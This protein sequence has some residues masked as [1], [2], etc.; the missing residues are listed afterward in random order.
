MPEADRKTQSNLQRAVESC[1]QKAIWAGKIVVGHSAN[2]INTKHYMRFEPELIEVCDRSS[3]RS[4][5][6]DPPNRLGS[7]FSFRV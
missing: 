4:A 6:L 2:D 1:E 3:C 7:C 5:S